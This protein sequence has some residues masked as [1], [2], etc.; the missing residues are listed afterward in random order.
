[1]GTIIE[2]LSEM[3]NE[4]KWTR[5]AINSY[6]IGNFEELDQI[7]SSAG[8][9]E[10]LGEIKLLCDEHL[11]HTKHSIIALYIS[12]IISLKKRLIDDTHL[13]QLITLFSDNRKWKIVEYLASRV[14]E[15]GENMLVLRLL[16]HC[17]ENT[18]DEEKKFAIWE[19]LVKVDFEETDI[20]KHLAERAA[21]QGDQEQSV[22]YYKKALYRYINFRNFNQIKDI[23]DLLLKQVPEEY[24]FFLQICSKVSSAVSPE[25]G[26]QL[27]FELYEVYRL[28]GKLERAVDILKL[29]LHNETKSVEARN[30]LIDCYR[31][32]YKDH[33]KLETYINESN[34]LQSYRNVEEAIAYFEK[35][36]SLDAGNFVYHKS[37]GI[38]RIKSIRGEQVVIDFIKKRGHDMSLKMAVNALTVLDKNHIWV[39]KSVLPKERLHEKVKEDPAWAL[40][41]VI[42]SFNN[43]A[44][45]RTIKS[46]LVPAVLSKNEWTAWNISARKMLKT[47]S[48]FGTN[49]ENADEYVVR[50][51]PISFE[52]KTLNIFKSE[53]DFYQ[54]VKILREF[55]SNS[56]PDST[57]FE[58]IYS[59]FLTFANNYSILND[60][61][62][63]S[64]L[65]T[66]RLSRSYG[67]LQKPSELSFA[68]ELKQEQTLLSIF[69]SIDD[70]D[71][72]RDFLLEVKNSFDDWQEKFVKIFP[73]HLTLYIIDELSA[74]DRKDELMKKIFHEAYESYRERPEPF[75]WL[76]RNYS[77]EQWEYYN[78]SMEKVLIALLHLLDITFRNISNKKDV[79][80]NRRI[81]RSIQTILFEEDILHQYVAANERDQVNRIYSLVKDIEE[82]DPS[83]K[84][85]LKHLIKEQIPDF[86][87]T[88]DDER[89]ETISG[90]LIVTEKSF[91]EKQ[92]ELKHIIEV[93]VPENSREIGAARELGDLREN[94]EYKAGKEKQEML[95]I[96]VSRL[97]S[98]IERS[99]IFD[100]AAVD[101]EKISFGTTAVLYN[102]ESETE[103]TFHIFGPW[104]SEPSKKIISYLSPFGAKLLNRREGEEFSFVINENKYSYIVRSITKA[105]FT[106]L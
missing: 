29:Y 83:K 41:T 77:F 5:A 22:A 97:K 65:L 76:A 74:S 62:V 27:L 48:L 94:A 42:K 54:R 31:E 44:S 100:E 2:S 25:R 101:T 61:V 21:Q 87:F 63:S 12:G 103:E 16:A 40:R 24:E 90:G 17:Y 6:T 38:G 23:W 84:I 56:D 71:L 45:I 75:T 26:S 70:G 58:E 69:Q 3:L 72:K 93:E 7:I 28:Q 33:S 36:I 43:S 88:G 67:F 104:E 30:E 102:T 10:E 53:K 20:V 18:S 46:E 9:K 49:P 13:V 32:M 95:N 66:K 47:S 37:W 35:H 52:E 91:I 55:V 50:E 80:T 78:I 59:Y 86:K 11:A 106:D 14:L 73:Y 81:N 64:Y 8:A 68:N 15:H 79:V 96:T 51:T 105:D 4:E 85:E 34:L 99:V 19:R 98:E 39:L 1:M 60:H 89:A 92:N 82:L 57:F